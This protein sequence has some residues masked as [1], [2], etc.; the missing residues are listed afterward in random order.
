MP[1]RLRHGVF[2][3]GA[4][5]AVLFLLC[6][7]TSCRRRTAK[8]PQATPSSSVAAAPSS[9]PSSSV[10]SSSTEPAK[11]AEDKAAIAQMSEAE[12]KAAA[13]S[14]F[15]EG[16]QHQGHRDCVQAL[17]RFELAQRLF[18][19]PTHLL[20][21][22]QCQALIGRL[23][24]AQESYSTLS[25]MTLPPGAPAAFREAKEAGRLELP[26]LAPRVPTLRVETTPSVSSLQNVVVKVNGTQMPADLI[27]VA[28]PLNPGRYHV[29]VTASP[30]KSGAGDM[31][32]KEGEAKSLEVKLS[33]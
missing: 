14:A 13:R 23:V 18:E 10:S 6:S 30:N 1:A 29:T 32:L 9:A 7:T 3:A 31:E 21:M 26:R 33:P 15:A 27:G 11:P 2:F 19:A 28:R 17:P 24:E 20:H 16:V 25:H 8:A 4:S 5:A 12:R 22:A